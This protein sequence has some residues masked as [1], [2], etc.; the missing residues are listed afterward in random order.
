MSLLCLY[1][2]HFQEHIHEQ[3]YFYKVPEAPGVQYGVQSIA[4]FQ[5]ITGTAVN[6]F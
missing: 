3:V 4:V 5:D 2:G 1:L 6:S